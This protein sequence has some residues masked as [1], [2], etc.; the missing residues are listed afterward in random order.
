M[1][2][3]VSSVNIISNKSGYKN[4]FSLN[5]RVFAQMTAECSDTPAINIGLT[6]IITHLIVCD[7]FTICRNPPKTIEIGNKTKSLMKS[8]I[9]VF[10][11][12]HIMTSLTLK[13][14]QR[15]C[16]ISFSLLLSESFFTD[17]MI[18]RSSLWSRNKKYTKSCSPVMVWRMD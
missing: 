11:V 15:V 1:C 7:P 2:G 17:S 9:L 13:S 18:L 4:G 6:T 12:S 3:K 8:G 16:I 14:S 5:L 10:F